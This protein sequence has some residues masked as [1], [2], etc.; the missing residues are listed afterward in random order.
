M[1]LEYGPQKKIEKVEKKYFVTIV[2]DCNMCTWKM[3]RR[4][5]P[6]KDEDSCVKNFKQ[7]FNNHNKHAHEGKATASASSDIQ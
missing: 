2:V 3:K 7:D 6:A 5:V 4:N 1:S